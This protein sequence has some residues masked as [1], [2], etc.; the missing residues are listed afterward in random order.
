MDCR[1]SGEGIC[2]SSLNVPAYLAYELRM[3]VPH[4]TTL[5]A[6]I[7][8]IWFFKDD[9]NRC[10]PFTK[11]RHR[12]KLDDLKIYYTIPTHVNCWKLLHKRQLRLWIT[13]HNHL[14]EFRPHLVCIYPV[15]VTSPWTL[16]SRRSNHFTY[17]AYST[18]FHFPYTR[19]SFT[20]R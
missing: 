5:R 1:S 18:I 19:E 16:Y 10:P 14:V 11:P 3:N 7:Y 13:F 8:I 20:K 4:Y 2:F 17:R 9:K 15:L 6:E 12:K